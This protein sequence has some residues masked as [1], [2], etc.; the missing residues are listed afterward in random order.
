MQEDLRVARRFGLGDGVDPKRWIEHAAEAACQMR[1]ATSGV[2][3]PQDQSSVRRPACRNE[4]Q[5]IA[6]EDGVLDTRV[7]NFGDF[8]RALPRLEVPVHPIRRQ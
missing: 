8:R 1:N 4:V 2:W 5:R 6:T 3:V 7:R